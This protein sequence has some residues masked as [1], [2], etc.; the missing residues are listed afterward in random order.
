ME[1][2]DKIYLDN[3]TTTLPKLPELNKVVDNYL[4]CYNLSPNRTI[5]NNDLEKIRKR[6]LN[7]FDAPDNYNVAFT[8]GA[9]LAMNIAVKSLARNNECNVITTNCEHHCVYRPLEEYNVKYNI[10]EYMDENQKEH[11]DKIIEKIDNNTSAVI[12]NHGSN[13]TGNIFNVEAACKKIKENKRDILFIVD[14]SQT[15]G[16]LDIS[17]K[18]MNADILIGAAH[19][20]LYG[21]PGIGYIIYRNDINL[22]PVYYGGTGIMSS[23][24][25]QPRELPN[26]LE[27]GTMNMIGIMALDECIKI[28]NKEKRNEYRQHEEELVRYFLRKSKEINNIKV[29]CGEE[30]NRTGVISFKIDGLDSN[31]VVAPYLL[32]RGNILVRSGLHCAPM[33]HKALKTFP[34]GTV[35]ISFSKNSKKEEIDKLIEVLKE[36]NE[37]EL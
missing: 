24:M 37:D 7:Y 15:A 5:G 16:F 23:K 22:E 12:M 32:E 10:A 6:V 2:N 8:Y 21:L 20:H 17:V 4:T 26:M 11:V 3:A 13:V 28:L 34:E 35:R 25:Q 33:I 36:L 27:A 31:Y 29:F 1:N 19:K 18:K 30:G 9:T 14:V